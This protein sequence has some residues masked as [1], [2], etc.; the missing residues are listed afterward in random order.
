MSAL[1][2]VPF[3]TD[4]DSRAAVKGSRDPL[5]IQPIWTRFGRHVVGNLTTVSSSVLDFTTLLLGYWFAE[6]IA[7]MQGPGSELATFLKWEQ[8]AAYARA[9][10]NGDFAFR[11]TE[12][13]RRNLSEGAQVTL[14]DNPTYQ[15]LGNQKIYGLWGLYTVPARTSKLLAPDLPRLAPPARAFVERHYVP[16]LAEFGG[17]DARRIREVLSSALARLNLD[18]ADAEM[19]G[20][21]AQ[22]LRPRRSDEERAFYTFYLLHGGP[23]DDTAGRQKQLAGLLHDTLEDR[24]FAWSPPAVSQLAKVAA[25]RGWE[26]L[27]HYLRRIQ[28]C[29]PVLAPASAVFTHLLGLDGK[30][31]DLVSHRLND[32][33]GKGLRTVDAA[34]FA[35]L[36]S[37][38]GAGDGPTGERW[39]EIA[40]ALAVGDYGRLVELL[41]EQNAAVMSQRGGAPWIELRGGRLHVRFRDEGGTL[42][43]R[44]DLPRLWRFPYFLNSLRSVAADLEP[45]GRA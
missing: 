19:V 35:E 1:L 41:L 8:L 33:W 32:A 7:D 4:L 42:P 25:G 36:R 11:G 28:T 9:K 16:V 13:V 39:A 10:V 40:V 30:P 31:P 43:D 20:A 24:A 12:R 26:D 17:R 18:G 29:E 5:G 3:L 21:A 27:A 23:D 22:A 38:I 34:A 45:T 15:I 44:N 2:Q 6:R 14:S 37:E